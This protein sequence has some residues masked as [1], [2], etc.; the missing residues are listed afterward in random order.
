MVNF[1]VSKLSH[2]KECYVQDNGFFSVLE[3][4]RIIQPYISKWF[5]AS[6]WTQDLICSCILNVLHFSDPQQQPKWSYKIGSAHPSVHF[7]ICPGIG[8]VSL[9][10]SKFCDGA[11]NLYEV[12]CESRILW[13]KF[14]CPR[15]WEM[16]QKQ[17]FLNLLK[18]LVLNFY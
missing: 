7:S 15:N 14:F 6:I 3:G 2:L 11:R 16:G 12:V 8:I 13:K 18:N 5:T 1:I 4:H 10:L 9:V 17:G